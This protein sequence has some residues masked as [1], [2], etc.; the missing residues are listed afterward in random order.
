MFHKRTEGW[1]LIDRAA[2][3]IFFKGGQNSRS[4]I[5]GEANSICQSH[6]I[7]LKGGKHPVRGGECPSPPP[8]K[9]SPDRGSLGVHLSLPLCLFGVGCP[10]L[11]RPSFLNVI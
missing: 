8:P 4:S 5:P 10:L 11:C 6:T 1:D 2:F 7:N 3:R 9:C